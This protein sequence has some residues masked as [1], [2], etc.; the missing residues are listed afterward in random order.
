ML[1][2]S[3]FSKVSIF[4][5]LTWAF[6]NALPNFVAPSMLPDFLPQKTINLGLDL[7]GGS[8]LVLDVQLED[9]LGN[10]YENLE[11]EVRVK[12]RAERINYT[13]LRARQDAVSFNVRDVAD[14]D[15]AREVLQERLRLNI[16]VDG[17]TFKLTFMES[18]LQEMNSYALNQTLE[19]LRSRVD[20]F[21]VAEPLIQRQGNR[22]VIVELPGIDDA[23]R[24]KDI[25]GRT[26]RLTFH[27]VEAAG[28]GVL[29]KPGSIVR[30][31][32]T[33]DPVSG[34][35]LARTP[36]LLKKRASLTGD[37]LTNATAAFD[38]QGQPAVDIAFD[39]RGTRQF[40]KLSTDNVNRR[41]AIVLDERVYSAPVFRE[42]ILG[43]RAQ[44][45]GNFALQESQDLATVL[46]AGALPAEVK[47]V[48]E[49][50]IG[51]SLGADSIAA[52]KVAISVGFLAVL[53]IMALFYGVLGM[54]ANV[55]LLFNV[56]LILAVM[57]VVGFT[58]TLPGMA[59]IVLTIG[60]AVDANV[61]IF[62]RI[63]EELSNGHK[64]L[65]AVSNA[66]NGVMSTILDANFTTLIAAIVLFAMGSGPIKGF[67]LT[68]SIGI[69]ASLF[70]AI[71]L[72]RLMIVAY[73]KRRKIR[74]WTF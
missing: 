5:V 10:A 8:H 63:R 18:A 54:A 9:V 34:Q 13:N 42:P 56:L 20:E 30:Y 68:L 14:V 70:T 49:R 29:A 67:A 41:F 48:E 74:S 16:D 40:A 33:R 7:Q 55:A 38:Q 47:I 50:T 57:S 24:A 37:R 52:S 51:P 28:A 22:R 61:L 60:M 4:A 31:E 25:I 72:T 59:G 32:E 39:A 36:Y 12:L 73:L 1:Q 19:V 66:F 45:S 35:V 44:I 27:L 46:N 71:M 64:P 3:L 2:F 15:T 6:F 58:L 26:A 69:L 53:V 11:D 17:A 65:P 62:E 43:G 23:E 21:G